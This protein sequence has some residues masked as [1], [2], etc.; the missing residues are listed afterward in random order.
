MRLWVDGEDRSDDILVLEKVL[1]PGDTYIDV[2]ANIGQ[3][4]LAAS[5]IVGRDGVAYGFEPHPKTYHYLVDNIHYNKARNIVT[6]NIAVGDQAGWCS[7]SDGPSAD[8]NHVVEDGFKVP[9]ACLNALFPEAKVRLLKIDVEGFE[10][11]VLRGAENLLTRTD[12]VYFETFEA[13]A[14]RYGS[15]A[16]AVVEFL[17]RNGF[18]SFEIQGDAIRQVKSSEDFSSCR[19]L[20]ACRTPNCL[21]PTFSAVT[22][23]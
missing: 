17:E 5:K 6:A 21:A 1:R 20:I 13:N 8:Q 2:G 11:S 7:I 3:L 9:Q 22:D 18:K 14:K 19:N 15:T 12:I 4:V 10:E 16:G 23:L